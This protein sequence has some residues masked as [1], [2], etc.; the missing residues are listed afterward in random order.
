[1]EGHERYD[2]AR[3]LTDIGPDQSIRLAVHGLKVGPSEID[4]AGV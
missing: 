3:V 4:S 2:C 1:M